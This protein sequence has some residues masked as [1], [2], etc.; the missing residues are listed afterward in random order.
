[1][2]GVVLF[3]V[4][5]GY[6]I[7]GWLLA[8]CIGFILV[9]GVAVAR[10]IT[11]PDPNIPDVYRAEFDA[12]IQSSNSLLDFDLYGGYV[13][14]YRIEYDQDRITYLVGSAAYSGYDNAT[15]ITIEFSSVESAGGQWAFV[16][17]SLR[18]R[19]QVSGTFEAEAAYQSM[20][21]DHVTFEADNAQLAA[22]PV[23]TIAVPLP[24]VGD[25][26]PLR[27]TATLEIAYALADGDSA[28]TTLTREFELVIIG[29]DYYSYY[30]RYQNW[31]RRRAAGDPRLVR[32]ALDR[33]GGGQC[34]GRGR[35]YLCV[36][37]RRSHYWIDL[38]FE[39]GDSPVE[40]RAAAWR[41][42]TR[43]GEVPGSNQCGAGR[44]CRTRDRPVTCRTRRPA[45]RRHFD[46]TGR[47]T[48]Q[49][50]R[51]GQPDREGS[52]ERDQR[53]CSGYAP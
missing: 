17:G 41:G 30:D 52:Q 45:Y 53:R 39:D 28:N 1:M 38:W 22:Y 29:P 27:A 20:S 18:L 37:H 31:Q 48:D 21:A 46:R 5:R 36:A 40:R 12:N 24:A 43:S 49:Q 2:M 7:H 34:A 13:W 6:S 14:D 32:A 44:V 11:V 15:P 35:R 8:G 16:A 4:Y 33:A 26:N 23:M 50:S 25:R 47:K 3:L 19:G 42:S 51:R 9:C 10:A